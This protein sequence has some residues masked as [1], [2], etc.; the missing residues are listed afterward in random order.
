VAGV[1]I[2]KKD[3]LPYPVYPKFENLPEADVIIDFSSTANLSGLLEYAKAQKIPAV[4]ATTGY[5][6]SDI[7]AIKAAGKDVPIFFSANMSLGVNLM[8]G[9]AKKATEIL[10]DDFD[11]EIIEKHHNQK[12][13]APSGTALM[14]AN[15]VNE[16]KQNKMV[17]EYDRHSKRQKRA[18]NEIGIHSVRGG[19]IAGEH[20]IIFAGAEETVSIKHEAFS[21]SIFA[22]GAIK[23]AKFICGKPNGIYDMN[24]MIK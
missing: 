23:A 20:E 2:F 14:I 9:L 7:A 4:L 13:D 19:T 22:A 8:I 5:S 21:R 1:D 17:Y 15:S 18:A 12:V 11:I 10:G 6:E 24:D 3:N 16:T